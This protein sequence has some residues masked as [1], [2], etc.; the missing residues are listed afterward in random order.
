MFMNLLVPLF[1]IVTT[2]TIRTS[3][4]YGEETNPKLDG[5]AEVIR[6]TTAKAKAHRRAGAY[7]EARAV[8]AEFPPVDLDQM[9]EYARLALSG[10]NFNLGISYY[11]AKDYEKA[12]AYLKIADQFDSTSVRITY[13]LGTAYRKAEKYHEAITTLKRSIRQDPTFFSSHFSLGNVYYKLREYD[14]ARSAYGQAVELN[15]V[16]VPALYM[17]GMTALRQG[18]RR[19]AAA[20]WDEVLEIEP[21]H[22]KAKSRLDQVR[23][24]SGQ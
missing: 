6:T 5:I 1:T 24:G 12:I 9:T 18:R 23:S 4:S 16:H 10:A 15:P 2:L 19:E 22:K 8:L 7:D 13:S 20:R 14:L 17:L 11:L 21:G 3:P